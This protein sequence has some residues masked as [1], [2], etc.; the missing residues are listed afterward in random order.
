MAAVL[1][2]MIGPMAGA[3]SDQVSFAP[4]KSY[5]AGMSLTDVTSADFN[6][7]GY[8]DLAVANSHDATGNPGTVS[9]LINHSD[10]TFLESST[11]TV[12][13]SSRGIT[14][15]DLDGDGRPDLATANS[16]SSFTEG[17]ASVLLNTTGET[18]TAG[19]TITGTER[20]DV[21]KGT[22]DQDIICGR[23]GNDRIKGAQ[24]NDV[25]RGGRGDDILK[26]GAGKDVL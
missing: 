8:P 6:G 7:D 15:D 24:G 25:I 4:A 17:N 11:Y 2:A 26:G 13:Y 5:A 9:V 1:L 3:A 18:K 22:K 20:D 19:C 23:G 12:G 16:G 14:S 21:L 10:G